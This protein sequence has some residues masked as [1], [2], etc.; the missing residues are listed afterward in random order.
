LAL[1]VAVSGIA[2]RCRKEV[3]RD[4][5]L[6][7]D[8]GDRFRSRPTGLATLQQFFE[9]VSVFVAE[10]PQDLFRRQP[11]QPLLRG[12]FRQRLAC[13]VAAKVLKGV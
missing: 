5:D 1:A 4:A 3:A 13:E 7:A 6:A 12:Q 9:P 2:V 11:P 8:T 10:P